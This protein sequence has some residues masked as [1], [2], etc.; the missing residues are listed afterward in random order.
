MSNFSSLLNILA[1]CPDRIPGLWPDNGNRWEAWDWH[2]QV[3]VIPGF[4][5]CIFFFLLGIRLR[6][7]EK[8]T[9]M[10]VFS[11]GLFLALA[12]VY[13]QIS[14]NMIRG[15]NILN[16]YAWDIFPFQLCSIPMFI[17]LIIPLLKNPKTRDV[18]FAFMG[19]FGMMGGFAALFINQGNLFSWGDVGIYIHTIVWHL[20][21]M[22][23][24]FFSIGYLRIG[25]GSYTRNL[26]VF[27]ITYLMFFS[28][29]LVA[30]A[31]NLFVPLIYG[32]DSCAAQ[33]TNMFY[34]GMFYNSGVPIL[35]NIWDISPGI[36]GYGWIICYLLYLV[37]LGLADFIIINI[38][39]GVY[40]L[41]SRQKFKRKVRR[42]ELNK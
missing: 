37:A 14:Y 40:K 21:L 38:Y 7:K 28:F 32:V 9:N 16:G 5:L 30:Q 17:S 23:L 35:K 15:F 41:F 10:I 18:C 27:L 6:Y 13:K 25:Q 42:L 22:M 4:I 39:F 34:I 8:A 33:Y 31:I 1:T 24:G 12:E 36:T 26:R 3:L 29:T 11:L 19:V 2:V 20:V